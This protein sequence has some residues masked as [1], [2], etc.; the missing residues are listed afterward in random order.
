MRSAGTRMTR[1]ARSSTDFSFDKNTASVFIRVIR[2][3]RV[4][5]F[6]IALTACSTTT[7][8]AGG[9]RVLATETWLAD[10]AQNVAGTRLH[11]D[12]LL[13]AGVDP[14]EYQPAPQ[15]AIKLAQANV[16]IVNGLGYESWLAKSLQDAGGD[17][18]LVTAT[19]GLTPLTPSG[20]R[21][22]P[23]NERAVAFYDNNPLRSFGGGREGVDPHMWM[24]P[25]NV[26]RYVENIRDALIK[27]DP[28]GKDVYAA[29][30]DAYIAKLKE[31]DASIKSQVAQ[32]PVQ[33]RVLVTNHDALGYFA[34]AYG[35]QVLGA[36][37]P[38]VTNESSPS[39]QQ[40]AALI[41]TVKRTHAPAIFLDASENTNLAD[42]I[43]SATGARVV[44]D[45]YVETLSAPNGPAPT[46]LA[47]MQHDAEVIVNA[48]K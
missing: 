48:L 37:V 21:P 15:D 38:S 29:N 26:V 25:L 3:L 12:V 35:F 28:A 32:V 23:P 31:L 40:M 11:V 8:T 44:T 9:L 30:A 27:A 34:S 14:H 5:I 22:P 36:V 39:A 17:Q 4:L 2:V 16:L 33:R 7:P 1:I 6:L 24:E 45:L 20:L 42:Q 18:T 10:I 47:M 41:D 19:D 43:A 46:Y 13:P